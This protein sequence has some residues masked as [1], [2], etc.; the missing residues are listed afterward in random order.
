LGPTAA[1]GP[2]KAALKTVGTFNGPIAM[3]IRPTN[4]PQ[5]YLVQRAG[6]IVRMSDKLPA[7]DLTKSTDTD[8]EHGVLGL[9][10]S[11][12]AALAYVSYTDTKGDS[13]IDEYPV[14]ENGT[15]DVSRKRN[16]LFVD[17][18]YP[19]HNGGDIVFGPD[20]YL[21]FGLGDGGSADDPERRALNPKS[22]LGKLLRI[23][24]SHAS[25]DKGYT[26]PTDN[27]FVGDANSLPE[28]WAIGLRNPWRFSFDAA[29]GDLWIGDVGQGE[30]EEVDHVAAAAGKNAGRGLNFGWSAFEGTHVH[31]KDQSAPKQTPP[32][33]E[34]P[35]GSD[36]CSITGGYVYHGKAIPSLVGQY[37]F[38]DYCSGLIWSLSPDGKTRT[39][40]AELDQLTSFGQGP[41]GEL[42]AMALNGP[43]AQLVPA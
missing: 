10:F 22:L 43:V 1:P 24:P 36:G 13:R 33:F 11:A 16:V 41:D 12:D 26:V 7:L 31:N 3:A 14:A 32:V 25:G 4:P 15:F 40:L 18:P 20:G 2:P 17:Q 27:P 19:N 21:Y 28:I 30:W 9:A 42:Y 37:V 29:T 8:S 5:T 23:D 6:V 39:K 38:G 34:Y 35:H